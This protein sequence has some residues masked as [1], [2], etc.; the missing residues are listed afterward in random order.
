MRDNDANCNS[1][2]RLAREYDFMIDLISKNWFSGMYFTDLQSCPKVQKPATTVM[3]GIDS[4]TC[5]RASTLGLETEDPVFCSEFL[6]LL[7]FEGVPVI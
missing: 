4:L 6:A 7:L 3:P 5:K 2:I 1:I